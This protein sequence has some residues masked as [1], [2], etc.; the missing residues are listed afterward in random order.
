MLGGNGLKKVRFCSCCNL[1]TSNRKA[2]QKSRQGYRRTLGLKYLKSVCCFAMINL[3]SHVPLGFSMRN[4]FIT[5][6]QLITISNYLPITHLQPNMIAEAIEIENIDFPSHVLLNHPVSI[7]FSKR[8]FENM[9][10]IMYS[11]ISIYVCR[12]YI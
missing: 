3:A 12:I 9:S 10:F 4:A 2:C 7:L 1:N 11:R 5:I 6:A 8:Y